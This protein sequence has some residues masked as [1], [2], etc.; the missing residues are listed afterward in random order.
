M[1]RAVLWAVL[2]LGLPSAARADLPLAPIGWEEAGFATLDGSPA[3]KVGTHCQIITSG[4]VGSLNTTCPG[5]STTSAT[6][7]DPA[8]EFDL[9]VGASHFHAEL[10]SEVE[11]NTWT[12]GIRNMSFT[13]GLVPTVGQQAIRG[14]SVGTLRLELFLDLFARFAVPRRLGHPVSVAFA[15]SH[16]LFPTRELDLRSEL[17]GTFAGTGLDPVASFLPGDRITLFARPLNELLLR[18]IARA[19][20]DANAV[21]QE[22]SVASTT[23]CGEGSLDDCLVTLQ[24]YEPRPRGTPR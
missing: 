17:L 3:G 4:P 7:F 14:Q 18:L 9:D 24:L 12:L 20:V 1:S 15:R 6:S 23:P 13:P 2:S 11:G 21:V 8:G 5:F 22:Y 10:V 16:A 19:S